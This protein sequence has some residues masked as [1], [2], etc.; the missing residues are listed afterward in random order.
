MNEL[1]NRPKFQDRKPPSPLSL[2]GHEEP[3]CIM[4]ML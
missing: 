4:E 1:E 3:S 2:D